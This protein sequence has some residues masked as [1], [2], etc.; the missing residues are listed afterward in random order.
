MLQA[1]LPLCPNKPSFFL[2][3]LALGPS[4]PR[5]SG[6]KLHKELLKL[7]MALQVEINILKKQ[8][9]ICIQSKDC[10]PSWWQVV[11][12]FKIQV[13]KICMNIQTENM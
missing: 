1:V 8:I 3:P 6:S 7:K 10:Q 9:E 12:D 13:S 11:D 4:G 2:D 5:A